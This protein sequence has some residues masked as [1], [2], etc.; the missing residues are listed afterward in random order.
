MLIDRGGLFGFTCRTPEH[1]SMAGY[2]LIIDL[3]GK[4][5]PLPDARHF[6]ERVSHYKPSDYTVTIATGEKIAAAKLDSAAS[7]HKGL[8]SDHKTGSWLMAAGTLIYGDAPSDGILSSLLMDFLRHG[9][10]VLSGCDGLFSA[11]IYNGL[12]KAVSVVTDPLGY[13][14]VFYGLHNGLA[15][16]GTSAL[17]IAEMI[18]SE[19]DETGAG[20]FLLTGRVLGRRTLWRDVKR[21]QAARVYKFEGREVRE[22]VYW[23]PA[24][25][26][27][28]TRLSFSEAAESSMEVCEHAFRR[29]LSNERKVWADLTGGF[30]TRFMTMLLDYSGIP[31]KANC[32]GPFEHPD[33][34]IAREI[35]KRM[36]WEFEHFELPESW[37]RECHEYFPEALGRGDA[38]I[39]VF[40]LAKTLWVHKKE[41]Q[42][43]PTLLSG[44]GGELW[45]GPIWW[46][47]KASLGQ[48]SFVHYDRQ[49]WSLMH[50]I[51][52]TVFS[53]SLNGRVREEIEQQFRKAGELNPHALNTVKLDR[54]WT[55]R[56]TGHVGAWASAASGLLR[57]I[58]V[59]FSKD[60][61]NHVI[62]L[63]YRYKVGNQIVRHLLTAY[64]PAL[65]KVIVEKGRMAEPLRFH[66]WFRL[67]PRQAIL[68]KRA[69]NKFSEVVFRRTLWPNER[70]IKYSSLELRQNILKHIEGENLLDPSQMHSG[71]LYQPHQFRRFMRQ[72]GSARFR[73]EEFLGRILTLEMAMRAVGSEHS[74]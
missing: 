50:P 26:E 12:S 1:K 9:D 18:Q 45:R 24:V 14:S 8:I 38:H 57:V 40:L 20:C 32:V 56:E 35:A 64:N 43:Y 33:V 2:A 37:P 5:G 54:I 49:I 17:A 59:L 71:Y 23:E 72:A 3:S 70:G 48:S 6:V 42:Q 15:F 62:S 10:S 13:F 21:L 55:Y 22:S 61:V 11:V 53:K 28:I 36:G 34:R 58:P 27:K 60:I 7:L 16:V 31:F 30:D 39:N 51:A 44:F 63:N 29:N 65:S 41:S 19:P 74:R 68:S 46:P 69:L 52:D 73:H 47:E 67:L 66:N 4:S 25:D